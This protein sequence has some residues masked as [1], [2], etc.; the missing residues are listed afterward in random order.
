VV[1]IDVPPEKTPIKVVVELLP[2]MREFLT[3]L[4]VAGSEADAL[5]SQTTADEVPVFV[6]VMLRFREDVP[7]FEP[8]MVKNFVPLSLKMLVVEDPLIVALTPVPGLIVIV[9]TALAPVIALIVRGK[10]SLAL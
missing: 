8:S 9:F 3:V 4:F 10:V 7:L 1:L 2:L 6:L 5:D